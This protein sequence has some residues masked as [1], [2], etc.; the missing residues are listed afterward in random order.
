[1]EEEEGMRG[2]GKGRNRR[3]GEP[4]AEQ[5]RLQASQ[6]SQDCQRGRHWPSSQG[7]ASRIRPA[8]VQHRLDGSGIPSTV[9]LRDRT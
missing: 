5:V 2:G 8:S 6:G 1:M 3:P 4:S 9:Q 7:P